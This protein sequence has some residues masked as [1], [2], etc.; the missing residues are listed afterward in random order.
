MVLQSPEQNILWNS[1][2]RDHL[3]RS[4]PY[5]TPV[6][7]RVIL[8]DIRSCSVYAPEGNLKDQEGPGGRVVFSSW[9]GPKQSQKLW[10]TSLERILL[11]C[12]HCLLSDLPFAKRL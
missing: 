9:V 1:S 11:T 5:L 8:P 3:P 2:T 4:P 10:K 7:G 12:G 6:V